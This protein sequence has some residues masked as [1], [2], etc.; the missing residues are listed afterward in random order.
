MQKVLFN[1]RCSAHSRGISPAEIIFGRK[2]RVPVYSKFDQG[3]PLTLQLGKI[4]QPATFVMPKGNNTAWILRNEGLALVSNNQIAPANTLV[5][6]QVVE[7]KT[8]SH[9]I[10]DMEVPNVQDGV[11]VDATTAVAEPEQPAQEDNENLPRRS[12]RMKF[13]VKKYDNSFL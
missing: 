2:L 10:P 8:I 4:S 7:N 11:I 12:N 13:N 9:P 5:D 6:S 1:H 3:E